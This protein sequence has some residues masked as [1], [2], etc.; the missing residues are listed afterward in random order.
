M[1][2]NLRSSCPSL[3]SGW[4]HTLKTVFNRW[5]QTHSN[6]LLHARLVQLPCASAGNV[7][8]T[9]YTRHAVYGCFWSTMEELSRWHTKFK[10]LASDNYRSLLMAAMKNL[11]KLHSI[12]ESPLALPAAP[13]RSRKVYS[14]FR[15]FLLRHYTCKRKSE[16]K[17]TSLAYDVVQGQK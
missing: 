1:F 15:A 16:I 12:K 6:W 8:E 3:P 9:N 14:K 10:I 17:T 13:F 11:G 2:L 4:L 5:L 7:T